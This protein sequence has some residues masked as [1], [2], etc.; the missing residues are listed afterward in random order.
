MNNNLNLN[1]VLLS[2]VNVIPN[3]VNMKTNN[4]AS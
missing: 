4:F 2:G 1:I 3:K